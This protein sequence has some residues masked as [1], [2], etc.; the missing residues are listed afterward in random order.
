MLRVRCAC[1]RRALEDVLH[2][3]EPDLVLGPL[4][5]DAQISLRPAL[6]PVLQLL[7]ILVDFAGQLASFVQLHGGERVLTAQRGASLQVRVACFASELRGERHRPEPE[8]LVR[9]ACVARLRE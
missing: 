9:I 3:E 2:L 1:P 7:P 6:H 5:S 4:D 8:T